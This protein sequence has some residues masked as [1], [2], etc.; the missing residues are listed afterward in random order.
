ML[1]FKSN[2]LKL[3]FCDPII[4]WLLLWLLNLLNLLS[5]ELDLLPT[6]DFGGRSV[7]FN[8]CIEL[9][10]LMLLLYLACEVFTFAL[11][12]FLD[13]LDIF[14]ENEASIACRLYFLSSKL[15]SDTFIGFWRVLK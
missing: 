6:P 5:V 3:W 10:L 12:I 13:S 7:D 9:Y 1:K 11:E 4:T 2:L 14:L 8:L 15:V